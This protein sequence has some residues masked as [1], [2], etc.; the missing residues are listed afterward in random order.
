MLFSSPK[1]V[2]SFRRNLYGPEFRLGTSRAVALAKADPSHVQRHSCAILSHCN[3]AEDGSSLTN[4]NLL[5]FFVYEPRPL[6]P[7]LISQSSI[8]IVSRYTATCGTSFFL[9]SLL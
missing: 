5:P 9:P 2:G 3:L 6:Y 4:N 1:T 8:I 7:L